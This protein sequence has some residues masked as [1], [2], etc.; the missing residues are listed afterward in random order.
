MCNVLLL[1]VVLT[2]LAKEGGV[3]DINPSR[4]MLLGTRQN[5]ASTSIPGRS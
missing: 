1:A 5:D 3:R 2:V 4:K